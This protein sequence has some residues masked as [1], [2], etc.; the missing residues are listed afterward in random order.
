MPPKILRICACG[1]YTMSRD[2]CPECGGTNL[3]TPH[4][5]KY[6]PED[7]FGRYRRRHLRDT[8]AYD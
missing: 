4:P 6:S 1:R 2:R 8:G 5:P 7:R 3:R